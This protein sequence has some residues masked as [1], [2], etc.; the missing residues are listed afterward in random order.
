MKHNDRIGKPGQWSYSRG[1]RCDECRKAHA[2]D[3]RKYRLRRKPRDCGFDDLR[4]R[5]KLRV[6][7]EAAQ[8]QKE[9][10]IHGVGKRLI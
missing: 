3:A 9:V 5:E 4:Q 7:L 1:C 8:Q 2:A 6:L 10:Y